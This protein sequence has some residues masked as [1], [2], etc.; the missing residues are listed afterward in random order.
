MILPIITAVSPRR[1]RADAAATH[2]GRAG[3]RRDPVG[4]DQDDGAARSAAPA[5]SAARCSAWAA[6]SARRSPS[7]D[8]AERLEQPFSLVAVRRRLHLRVQD[9]QHAAEFNSPLQTGAYIAAGLVLFV[10]TFVVNAA[11][12][13]RVAEKG[14]HLMTT[15]TPQHGQAARPRAAERLRKIKNA[16][17][18]SGHRVARRRAGA[19]GLAALDVISKGWHAHRRARLVDRTPAQHDLNDGAGGGA[20]HAIVG[21]RCSRS[22]CAR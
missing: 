11:A 12:P 13:G 10:L 9:R 17:P 18:R 3:P 7:T 5:S 19:A 22:V 20:Y 1:V 14:R 4:D 21:H 15:A 2:R 6:R 16:S 8:P